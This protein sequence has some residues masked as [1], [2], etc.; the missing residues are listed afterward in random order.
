MR[1]HAVVLAAILLLNPLG[2]RAADLVVWWEQGFN[3][4]EDAAVREIISAFEGKTGKHVELVQPSVEDIEAEAQ[5]AVSAGQPPDFLFGTNTDY[6]YGQWAE[7][8]R[9]VDLSQ[10][11][12]PFASLFDPDALRYA[13]LLDATAGRR[14]L[15]ALP[16]GFATNN[17]HVWRNLL[18]QAGFTLADVPKQWEPFWSFWCDQVQPAVRRATGRGDLWGVGLSMSVEEDTTAEFQQF[19]EA[20]QAN[21]I[22][23]DGKLIIDDPEIRRRLIKAMSSY[24]AIYSKGCTPRDADQ[25]DNRGN[26]EA[27]LAQRVVMT[28]NPSLS[29]PNALK[30]DHPEDYYKN[31][32][33]IAWPDATDGQPLAL[34]IGFFSATAFKTGG[35]VP[36]VEEF[37]HFLV[38]N[39]WLAHYLDW[40]HDRFMPAMPKLLDAPFWL[41]PSDPHRMT[42][43]I[44]F[45]TRPRAQLLAVASRDWRFVLPEREHVWAKAVHRIVTEG[46]SPEQAVD[47][48]I[49]RIKQILAE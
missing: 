1:S 33:T 18:E 29:I 13:T 15:H 40:S 10:A 46:I 20:Y 41:D 8:G 17:V 38:E 7:E 45:M 49:A 16:M 3:P 23:G 47:E 36:L 14:A 32:A 28:V 43:A 2:A 6:Y 11:I 22:S 37:V 39:G 48:A 4:E 30:R 5:A 35:H 24:T 34:G 25:W 12:G 26:N 21:Y 19:M 9:L 31:T 44:Q 42:A 27:F